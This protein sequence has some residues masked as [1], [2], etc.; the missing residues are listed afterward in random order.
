[1]K[2]AARNRNEEASSTG[3]CIEEELIAGTR[4]QI[5][6]Q[7]NTKKTGFEEETQSPEV[8]TLPDPFQRFWNRPK[9]GKKHH[10]KIFPQRGLTLEINDVS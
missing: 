2:A 1:M 6:L 8:S 3:Y 4:S 5:H 10:R 7:R 9:W